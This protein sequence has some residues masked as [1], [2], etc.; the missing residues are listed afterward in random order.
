VELTLAR[1]AF[2]TLEAGAPL[3]VEAA[4]WAASHAGDY[5]GVVAP[6]F[7]PTAFTNPIWVDADADG[8][9]AA[10]GLPPRSLRAGPALLALPLGLAVIA[11]V[12][13]SRRTRRARAR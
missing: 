8:R 6:G 5:A 11:I 9:F 4:A 10:P 12:H 2:L 7:I 13:L 1:D 3:D